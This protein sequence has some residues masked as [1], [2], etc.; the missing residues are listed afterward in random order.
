[1][2]QNK[3]L[4][5]PIPFV[6]LKE[7]YRY[8]EKEIDSTLKKVFKKGWF[9][10]G[11]NVRC[12]E[13]E[14]SSYNGAKFCVGVGSGTE[15]LHLALV[16][17][18]VKKGD[19]VITVANTAFPTVVAILLAGARPVF[20]DID[21]HTYNMNVEEVKKVITKRTKVILPVHLFGYPA[22]MG[23]IMDIARR[24]GLRVIEDACQAHGALYKS[25][26]GRDIRGYG[27]L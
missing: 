27:M 2:A 1:M 24:F 20:V 16:A 9:I 26:K 19:E 25:K 21:P 10:L 5:F 18:G 8:I 17:C 22:E 11:K 4:N 15:A 3:K 6:N 13:E 14:F 7:Q 12:F 23:P